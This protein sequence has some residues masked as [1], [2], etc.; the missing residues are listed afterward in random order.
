MYRRTRLAHL[1]NNGKM[2]DLQSDDGPRDFETETIDEEAAASAFPDAILPDQ[3][4]V[5]D[6]I[7]IFQSEDLNPANEIDITEQVS[8][9][10]SQDNQFTSNLVPTNAPNSQ[11]VS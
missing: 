10:D 9:P 4:M 7:S 8:S 2:L 1:K 11:L 3:L 5:M 6:P